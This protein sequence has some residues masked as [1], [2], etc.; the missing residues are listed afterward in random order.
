MWFEEALTLTDGYEPCELNT[1]RRGSICLQ[2]VKLIWLSNSHHCF[3]SYRHCTDAAIG[4]I[5]RT[6]MTLVV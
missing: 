6:D 3:P 1:R 5:P 2:N 4:L